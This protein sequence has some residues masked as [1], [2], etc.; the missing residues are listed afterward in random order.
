M[1]LF[2]CSQSGS[3][4]G[5]HSQ[6][7]A[8]PW[9]TAHQQAQKG[10]APNQSSCKTAAYR[11]RCPGHRQQQPATALLPGRNSPGRQRN[12]PG[13]YRPPSR[14]QTVYMAVREAPMVKS[15]RDVT[16]NKRFRIIRSASRF[17]YRINRDSGENIPLIV[18]F[19]F[20]YFAPCSFSRM[21]RSGSR[22]M[23]ETSRGIRSP[24]SAS[25]IKAI[26]RRPGLPD[27]SRR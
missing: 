13:R 21:I 3:A 25:A 4:A 24:A 5:T 6:K 17:I 26:R 9:Q 15:G 14:K 11:R 10:S 22:L 2:H 19:S 20:L 12:S 18:H 27:S 8:Q 1:W 23:T 16:K 7:S